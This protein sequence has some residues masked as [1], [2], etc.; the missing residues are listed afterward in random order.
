MFIFHVTRIDLPDWDEY[1]DFVMVAPTAEVA[2][3]THP[4]AKDANIYIWSDEIQSWIYTDT[5][6][7]APHNGW[8]DPSRVDV[9]LIGIAHDVTT[10]I[11][12]TN[13]RSG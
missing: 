12:T 3:Y 2:K 8:V 5:G 7:Y 9:S 13:Y 10:R 6:N 11:I 1:V 4:S